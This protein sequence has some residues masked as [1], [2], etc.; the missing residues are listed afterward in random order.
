MR[1]PLNQRVVSGYKFWQKT[2]YSAH[3]LGTD[4]RA[5][6]GTPVYAP[7]DGTIIYTGWGNQGGWWLYFK[8]SNGRIWRFAHLSKFHKRSGS[9]KEGTLIAT[10]GNTGA[11]T[12][13]PHLHIDIWKKPVNLSSYTKGDLEDPEV[14]IKVTQGA[15]MDYKFYMTPDTGKT[16]FAFIKD[17]FLYAYTDWNKYLKDSGGDSQLK[18][19]KMVNKLPVTEI[20]RAVASYNKQIS[21]LNQEILVRETQYLNERRLRQ[22]DKRMYESQVKTLEDEYKQKLIDAKKEAGQKL[23]ISEWLYDNIK[24]FNWKYWVETIKNVIAKFKGRR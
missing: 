7:T 22:N 24:N 14:Y 17:K 5:S 20:D 6:I 18:N 2:T 3:H 16:I 4:Y 21:G 8:D 23:N 19:V 12:T 11:L 15:V 13:S 9:V 1:F 10:T